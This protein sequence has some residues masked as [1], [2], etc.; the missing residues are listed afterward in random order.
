MSSIIESQVDRPKK[1]AWQKILLDI[2]I[3]LI[4]KLFYV[5][6]VT[7]PYQRSVRSVEVNANNHQLFCYYV[8]LLNEKL[9]SF[10]PYWP[11]WFGYHSSL[12]SKWYLL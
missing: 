7:H 6:Y 12:A 4:G 3:C 11:D 9:C 8:M 5:M 10:R 1:Q 2:L